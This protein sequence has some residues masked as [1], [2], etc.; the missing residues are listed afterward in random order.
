MTSRVALAARAITVLISLLTATATHAA[1]LSF[2]V[3]GDTPYDDAHPGMETQSYLDMLQEI[4]RSDAR[5]VVHV[6]DFKGG[7]SP[8]SDALFE[9][10]R[11]EFDMS[12]QPRSTCS[13]SNRTA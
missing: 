13:N 8:C 2:A 3:F 6:G 5:F 4:G 11:T 7:G 9:Q 10:R 12:A 1:P